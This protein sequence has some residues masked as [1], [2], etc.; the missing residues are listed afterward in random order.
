M[1][2]PPTL[3]PLSIFT[4]SA[5]LWL[6]FLLGDPP[7]PSGARGTQHTLYHLSGPALQALP[8]QRAW[9]PH[10]CV[11]PSRGPA[12]LTVPPRRAAPSSPQSGG[13]SSCSWNVPPFVLPGCVCPVRRFCLRVIS[14]RCVWKGAGGHTSRTHPATGQV[15]NPLHVHVAPQ[16]VPS[17]FLQI[18]SLD[19]VRNT[20]AGATGEDTKAQL[21]P[22]PFWSKV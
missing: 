7:P 12:W 22:C 19:L 21:V 5:G 18:K 2:L 8:L 16:I 20:W 13:L 14:V 9:V 15:F 6:W 4:R 3:G 1:T 17:T 10:P 11:S